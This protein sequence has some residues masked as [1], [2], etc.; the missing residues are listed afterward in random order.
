[1]EDARN[2]IEKISI[3]KY[4]SRSR[5]RRRPRRSF[6]CLMVCSRSPIAMDHLHPTP[7][8]RALCGRLLLPLLLLSRSGGATTPLES[9]LRPGQELVD[10]F[11][12]F[13]VPVTLCFRELPPDGTFELR[14]SYPGTQ[15]TRFTFELSE[16]EPMEGH[17][18]GRVAGRHL[19]DTEKLVFST[20]G[21]GMLV[22]PSLPHPLPPSR[23]ACTVAGEEVSF[24]AAGSPRRSGTRVNIKLDTLLGGVLPT[25]ALHLLLPLALCMSVAGAVGVWLLRSPKSP[26]STWRKAGGPVPRGTPAATSGVGSP[27]GGAGGGQTPLQAPLLSRPISDGGKAR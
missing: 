13:A 10:A 16:G 12:A 26:L 11:I 3:T 25:T 20:D 22:H 9:C 7:R 17:L 27:V 21:R 6:R 24:S 15:P 23:V 8:S 18:P 5:R 14:L 2:D 4:F 19:L 1:M